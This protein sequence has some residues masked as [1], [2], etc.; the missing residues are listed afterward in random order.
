[1]EEN[2]DKEELN[3]VEKNTQKSFSKLYDVLLE[4]FNTM[5]FSKNKKEILGEVFDYAINVLGLNDKGV[6]IKFYREPIK[7]YIKRIITGESLNGYSTAENNAVSINL[8]VSKLRKDFAG[9]VNTIIHECVHQVNS[10]KNLL[11][12]TLNYNQSVDCYA[13]KEYFKVITYFDSV[14]IKYLGLE[15]QLEKKLGDMLYLV[16]EDEKSAR[17][18]AGKLSVEFFKKALERAKEDKNT[19]RRQ[20]NW[21]RKQLKNEGVNTLVALIASAIFF[22]TDGFS[23]IITFF[24]VLQRMNRTPFCTIPTHNLKSIST[25]YR[26]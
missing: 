25:N 6:N 19:S 16:S 12:K 7:D 10:F 23:A 14:D 13:K 24:I 1:M 2:F 4:K 11:S 3:I 21:L 20:V 8:S 18:N 17:L 22:A 5:D 26:L 15:K 9:F